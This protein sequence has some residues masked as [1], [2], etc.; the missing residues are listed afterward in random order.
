MLR[1]AFIFFSLLSSFCIISIGGYKCAQRQDVPVQDTIEVPIYNSPVASGNNPYP[2]SP[3]LPNDLPDVPSG[4]CNRSQ[5][6]TLS[7]K[8]GASAF[9]HLAE[10]K[11]EEY[12]LGQPLNFDPGCP[13]VFLDMNKTKE[14]TYKGNLYVA[15]EG[16]GRSGRRAIKLHQYSSGRAVEDNQ[17]NKWASR[18]WKSNSRNKVPDQGFA[19]FFEDSGTRAIILQIK[20]VVQYDVSDGVLEYRGYGDIWYKMFRTYS[21][22]RGD[23]CYSGGTYVSHAQ[24]KPKKPNRR[25]WLL[26]IGPYS[27]LPDGVGST[28]TEESLQEDDPECYTLLGEFGNLNLNEAF[29]VNL[30]DDHP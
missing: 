8:Y 2:T 21:G 25:C 24:V 5:Y 10:S 27:C 29:N 17:Y 12:R 1:K 15:F 30:D 4:A 14:R 28:F 13:R 22:D 19:A 3:V 26:G 23:A 11:L 7:E 16:E 20:R 18:S 6:R 9:L